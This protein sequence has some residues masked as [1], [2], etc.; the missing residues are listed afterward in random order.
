MLIV[1][2]CKFANLLDTKW[3]KIGW[4][5]KTGEKEIQL[6]SFDPLIQMLCHTIIIIVMMHFISNVNLYYI[7]GL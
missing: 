5:C 6:R 2:D 1:N 7:E 3:Q 4:V